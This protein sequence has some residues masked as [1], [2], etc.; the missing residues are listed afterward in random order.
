MIE[1]FRKAGITRETEIIDKDEFEKGIEAFKLICKKNENTD[2]FFTCGTDKGI[3]PI[4]LDG[5]DVPLMSRK[6][7]PYDPET[8]MC[9]VLDYL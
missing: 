9:R 1:T 3:L 7:Q 2:K 8:F 6:V 4:T 5:F